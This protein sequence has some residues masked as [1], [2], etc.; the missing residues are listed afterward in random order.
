MSVQANKKSWDLT[1][2]WP[3]K[4]WAKCLGKQTVSINMKSCSESSKTFGS[5]AFNRVSL[6]ENYIFGARLPRE[7]PEECN[8]KQL[9]R[10]LSCRGACTAGK[11]TT[12]DH[13]VSLIS[14]RF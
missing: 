6:T 11:K 8:V 14:T 9:K 5:S 3:V 1:L 2:E 7:V 4:A 13:E 10:C 12:T